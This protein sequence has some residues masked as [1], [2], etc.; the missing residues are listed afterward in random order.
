MTIEFRHFTHIVTAFLLYNF[1]EVGDAFLIIPQK[2]KKELGSEIFV[3]KLKSIWQ[4]DSPVS[5]N[6]LKLL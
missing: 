2:F 5:K 6:F 4:T 1:K 3:Y